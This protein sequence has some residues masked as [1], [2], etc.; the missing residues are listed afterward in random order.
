ML[1]FSSIIVQCQ[2]KGRNGEYFET[3]GGKFHT[4]SGY[5][6]LDPNVSG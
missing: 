5:L 3:H 6:W 1:W 2:S 4:S